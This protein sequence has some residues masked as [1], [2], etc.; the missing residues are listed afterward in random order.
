MNMKPIHGFTLIELLVVIAIIALLMGM[1]IPS[2]VRAREITRE[3]VC[4]SNLRQVYIAATVYAENNARGTYPLEAT[5]HNPHRPLL[6]KLEAYEDTGLLR[7][8]YCTEAHFL[9]KGANDPAGGTPT[10]G[11]DSV[12]DTDENNNIGNITYIYWSFEKNKTEASGQTWRD[13]KVFFP[14]ALTTTGIR[15][16]TNTAAKFQNVKSGSSEV[17]VLSDFFRQKGVFP[18]GRKGG[19]DAGGLNI[20]FLDGHADIVFG[21]PQDNYK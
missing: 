12:I 15:P 10:G 3:V 17:W 11:V 9:E 4:R 18:H 21:R 8:F 5:E 2:L 6:E 19:K 7:A 1:L 20:T 14:R 16:V 13:A